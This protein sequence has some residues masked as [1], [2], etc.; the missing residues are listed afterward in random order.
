M[1]ND[2][3]QNPLPRPGES[4]GELLERMIAEGSLQEAKRLLLE[5]AHEFYAVDDGESVDWQEVCA[6][7]G[8]GREA[9][10]HC[11]PAA[12]FKM[13][14]ANEESHLCTINP[15]DP[16]ETDLFAGTTEDQLDAALQLLAE[17]EVRLRHL[18][19]RAPP[20]AVAENSH[21]IDCGC[22]ISLAPV[23][24]VDYTGPYCVECGSAAHDAAIVKTEVVITETSH[25]CGRCGG[26]GEVPAIYG[27]GAVTTGEMMPCPACLARPRL[28]EPYTIEERDALRER[29]VKLKAMLREVLTK[30]APGNAYRGAVQRECILRAELLLNPDAE[31]EIQDT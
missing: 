23:M 27:D 26:S 12:F 16:D 3:N 31:N 22:D 19:W 13:R 6:C 24:R 15:E 25:P 30:L 18:E 21:C 4:W 2:T 28:S 10:A 17:H 11:F 8:D 20:N 14:K 9:P 1:S 5:S 29:V 7:C